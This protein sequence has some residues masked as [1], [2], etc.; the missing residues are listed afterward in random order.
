MFSNTLISY[1]PSTSNEHTKEM[2]KS[3]LS[4]EQENKVTWRLDRP[5]LK[6]YARRQKTDQI[7]EF[8]KPI[9]FFRSGF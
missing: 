7:D 3:E 5:D 2:L 6:I 4:Q 8:T 9:I 1:I